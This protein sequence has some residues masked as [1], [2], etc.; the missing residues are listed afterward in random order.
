MATITPLGF[1]VAELGGERVHVHVLVPPGA[2]PHAFEPR[3][4]DLAAVADAG[5]FVQAGAGIDD[6]V[7]R[8]GVAEGP[9]PLVL[10]DAFGGT[11]PDP[12]F[13]LDPIGVRDAVLP[14]LEQ[15][16]AA[17]DPEGRAH[18]AER[19]RAF[20]H[21]L[22]ALDAEIRKRLAGVPRRPLVPTHPAWGGFAARYGI[23]LL[24]PVQHRGA[25]EPTP[26]SLAGLADTA[27]SGGAVAVLVE[28]QLPAAAA[29]ALAESARRARDRGRSARRSARARARRLRRAAALR[30]RRVP[31]RPDGSHAMTETSAPPVVRIEGVSVTRDG[32]VVLEDIRFDVAA[33]GLRGRVRT[34]RRGQ[35]HAAARD[36]RAGAALGRAHRGAAASPPRERASIGNGI[37]YVPQRHAFPADFPAH[38]L[39]VV[40]LGRLHQRE[41]RALE[42]SKA[43]EA[44]ARV[45]IAELAARPVG[46]L[47]G[48]EQR[49][50]TLAQALCAS[51]KLLILD[52]PTVGLDL[53]AE[54]EF[55]ALVRRLQDELG[56]A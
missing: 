17:A 43:E 13:W 16:L 38:A 3:P 45:G 15:A 56:L 32:R 1:L 30:R 34:E 8:L 21:T 25:E 50:V 37:G 10:L 52:E 2:S 19:R 29:E 48:G 44:L 54:Q 14:A 26:R 31:P 18:Y 40:R 36:P 55:Y 39:D 46:R 23:S 49:R 5:L 12:H 27:R 51:S 4:S 20:A 53:P 24:E 6:W 35:D 22:T 9:K 7:A 28:P 41:G 33:G 11:A 47:S 42:R